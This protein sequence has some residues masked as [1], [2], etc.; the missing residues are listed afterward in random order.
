MDPM[1]FLKDNWALIV[2]NPWSFARVAVICAAAGFALG[3]WIGKLERSRQSKAGDT[4]QGHP[5]A[6]PKTFEYPS[7]GGAGRN[8]L[9]PDMVSVFASKTYAFAVRVPAGK[10]LR[11]CMRGQFLG[12]NTHPGGWGML[13][14]NRAGWRHEPYDFPTHTQWYSAG[15]GEADLDI[16]FYRAGVVTIEGFEDAGQRPTW[17]KTLRVE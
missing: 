11:V 6:L 17:T 8:V 1:D 5:H 2:A 7:A 3:R 9:S 12:D 14:S 10:K 15:A 16:Q 4:D 13:V